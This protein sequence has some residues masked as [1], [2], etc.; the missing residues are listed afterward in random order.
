MEPYGGQD[1]RSERAAPS[2]AA[3]AQAP[4][5]LDYDRTGFRVSRRQWRALMVLTLLNTV[6]LG[7]FVAG[8]ATSN[9]LKA[10]WQQFQARRA[11]RA[12][13]RQRAA[14]LRVL[15]AHAF[16]SDLVIVEEDPDRATALLTGAA[17]YRPQAYETGVSGGLT[18]SFDPPA[19]YTGGP[20]KWRDYVAVSSNRS[21]PPVF[22]GERTSPRGNRRLVIVRYHL[23]QLM[24]ISGGSSG[25]D[26]RAAVQ[27][28]RWLRA[29]ARDTASKDVLRVRAASEDTD[30]SLVLPEVRATRDPAQ[31]GP[32]HFRP[33][34]TFTLLAGQADPA[35][36]S[37]FTIPY[38]LDGQ[39]GVIDGWLRDNGLQLRPRV[40]R[41]RTVNGQPG[42]DLLA[43]QAT[44]SV[45][46]SPAAER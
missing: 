38:R 14:E 40:G 12:A 28:V 29:T 13:E 33:D 7:W 34:V 11:Q 21:D 20:P 46:T 27:S 3:P 9:L 4:T 42:W 5:E 45:T 1:D 26:A 17:G 39:P 2:P 22:I 23:R 37:H 32:W 43:G 10:Q 30:L 15:L 6:M 25:T 44:T 8:P 16:P 19:V 41:P 18:A 24:N 35:D 36:P 31:S